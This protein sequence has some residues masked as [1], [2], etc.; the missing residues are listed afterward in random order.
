MACTGG[1][2][3]LFYETGVDVTSVEALKRP[4]IWKGVTQV[5]VRVCICVPDQ[6]T[7]TLQLCVC[8]GGQALQMQWWWLAR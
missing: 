2:G 4:E 3:I 6:L 7:S 5:C 8:W 1:S